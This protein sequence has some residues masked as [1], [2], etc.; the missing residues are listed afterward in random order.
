MLTKSEFNFRFLLVTQRYMPKVAR[1]L[2]REARDDIEIF[3]LDEAQR[4]WAKFLGLNDNEEECGQA[5]V[6]LTT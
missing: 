2:I 1:Q 4:I 5:G 3:G 6:R